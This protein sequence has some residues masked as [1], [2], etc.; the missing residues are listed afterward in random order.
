MGFW[1]LLTFLIGV[2]LLVIG[3]LRHDVPRSIKIV[4]LLFGFDLLL[5]AGSVVLLLP[6]SD[7][8]LS[9]LLK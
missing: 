6:G 3:A 9:E 8:L 2:L 1:Y 4:I 5:V 7:M